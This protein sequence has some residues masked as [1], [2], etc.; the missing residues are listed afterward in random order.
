VSDKPVGE[1]TD[2]QIAAEL[3]KSQRK[4]RLIELSMEAGHRVNVGKAS[5]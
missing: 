3:K 2:K 5:G 1:L 4:R